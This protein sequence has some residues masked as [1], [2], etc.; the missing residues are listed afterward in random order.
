VLGTHEW[1][2]D[3]SAYANE[4]QQHEKMMGL[5]YNQQFDHAIRF[6]E[7]LKPCFLGTMTDFYIKWIDRCNEMKE[8]G[9]S[10]DWDGVYRATTK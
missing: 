6:C 5:Y 10:E 2:N 9:L 8:A 4:T 3:N 7:D 1:W